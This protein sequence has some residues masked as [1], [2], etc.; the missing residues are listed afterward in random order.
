MDIRSGLAA[1]VAAAGLAVP[2]AYGADNAPMEPIRQFEAALDKGD[3]AA[4]KATLVA[5]PAITDELAPYHWSGA[6][7]FDTW[8]ADA[9][10]HDAVEGN[11]DGSSWYGEPVRMSIAGDRGYVVLP[12]TYTFT[13]KGVK[14]RATGTI[15]FALAREGADWK[16]ATW[17]WTSP[18]AV[19]VK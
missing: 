3:M 5:A 18:E 14:M 1:M 7:A 10:R 11:T 4:A 13:R 19:P 2:A 15:T 6:G 12:S 16:I 9:K 17:T 8:L